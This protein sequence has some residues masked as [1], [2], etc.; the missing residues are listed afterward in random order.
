[1][2]ELLGIRNFLL[3][4]AQSIKDISNQPLSQKLRLWGLL[5]IFSIIVDREPAGHPSEFEMLK[6]Q[7][8]IV[9]ILRLEGFKSF[10]KTYSTI[11]FKILAIVMTNHI[12]IL[13]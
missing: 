5:T 10:H 3:R 4:K 7:D 11:Q 13:C 6:S 9:A 12:L 8:T 1:L 2:I